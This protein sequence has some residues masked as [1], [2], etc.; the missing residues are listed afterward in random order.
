MALPEAVTFHFYTKIHSYY[1]GE[2]KCIKI[3]DKEIKTREELGKF[4]R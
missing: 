3:L 2:Y 4:F 1:Q